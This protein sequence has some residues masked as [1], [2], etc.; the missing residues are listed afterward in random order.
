MSTLEQN[1]QHVTQ[2]LQQACEQAQ[3]NPDAVKLLAVS[4]TR[5]AALV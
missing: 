5:P 2:R 3:R 1:Y 4:E